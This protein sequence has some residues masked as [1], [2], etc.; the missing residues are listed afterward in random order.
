MRL[1]IA[2]V[3]L[4]ALLWAAP[5]SADDFTFTVPVR[6]ENMS[7]IEGA[8]VNCSVVNQAADGTRRAISLA[9]S[10]AVPVTAGA[11]NGNIT[12]PVN[13]SSSY[14][15]A[16]ATH[17]G[18]TLSYRWRMPDGTLFNRSL[19]PGE[20]AREYTRYTGQTVASTVD[21]VGGAIPR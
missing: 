9:P 15:R 17:W 6:I 16:D 18:C 4:A 11:F 5:A 1:L 3:A 10:V 12:V 19:V 7:H 20:R 8:Q 14:T 2:P 21:S 13:V